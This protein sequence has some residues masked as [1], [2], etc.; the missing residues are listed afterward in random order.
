MAKKT[1]YDVLQVSQ[2]A[3]PETIKAA[4]KSLV[5]RYPPDKQPDSLDAEKTIKII[6]RAY[7]VLSDPVKRAGYD[8][9]FAEGDEDQTAG[10]KDWN[11][12][13]S[14]A[15]PAG[16]GA[17]AKFADPHDRSTDQAKMRDYSWLD[18][19]P[20]VA[21]GK[22]FESLVKTGFHGTPES[23]FWMAIFFALFGL[24]VG[25][26]LCHY[27]RTKITKNMQNRRAVFIASLSF[28]LGLMLVIVTATVLLEKSAT[29][30][31]S[32][33][34]KELTRQNPQD[35]LGL[36][37]NIPALPT[38]DLTYF[39]QPAVQKAADTAEQRSER[40]QIL[41]S[42]KD[43]FGVI[44]EARTG[45][46][47]VSDLNILGIAFYSTGQLNDAIEVFKQAENAYPNESIVKRN[48]GDALF[49]NGLSDKALEKYRE[50]LAMAPADQAIQQR[51][52]KAKQAVE[53]IKQRNHIGDD[54]TQWDN[55]RFGVTSEKE[56]NVS[57]QGS[58]EA[59]RLEKERMEKEERIWQEA[60]RLKKERMER[61]EKQENERLE[62]LRLEKDSTEQK[63]RDE[64]TERKNAKWLEREQ[65]SYRNRSF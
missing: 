42:A 28:S 53:R 37:K 33:I 10:S 20:G 30:S 12:F 49:S 7:E 32:K 57:A 64:E 61:T 36:Y 21:L 41:F 52:A 18:V 55:E 31:S 44:S 51:V 50:A 19:L 3:D 9:A 62:K 48:L 2:N 29:Q 35:P 45:Q 13:S 27:L 40:M 15:A 47:L 8:A 23:I 26:F 1:L 65:E 24:G 14:R 56:N 16:Y 6:N 60:D 43:Y 5:Q 17:S 63:S 58:Q 34:F 11:D 25:T 38:L 22:F 4:Y 54:K 59:D 39:D 46:Y